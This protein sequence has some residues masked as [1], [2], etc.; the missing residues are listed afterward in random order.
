MSECLASFLSL[1]NVGH[2]GGN[3]VHD[4]HGATIACVKEQKIKWPGSVELSIE[5]MT[6]LRKFKEE[7]LNNSKDIKYVLVYESQFGPHCVFIAGVNTV[8]NVDFFENVNSWGPDDHAPRVEVLKKKNT[9]FKVRARWSPKDCESI[10]KV[11][12]SEKSKVCSG[13]YTAHYCSVK[14]SQ[15]DWPVHENMC[16]K[17]GGEFRPL[18]LEWNP[19]KEGSIMNK[20][21][22]TTGKIKI[23]TKASQLSEVKHHNIL[24]V[25]KQFDDSINKWFVDKFDAMKTTFEAMGMTEFSERCNKDKPAKA[26]APGFGFHSTALT[27]YSQHEDIIG[28]ISPKSPLCATLKRSIEEGGVLSYKIYINSHQKDGKLMVNPCRILRPRSW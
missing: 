16:K 7:D 19:K 12:L 25:Q 9:V 2:Q 20:K 4:F 18:R 27:V 17:M 21:N 24:K 3:W 11:C 28:F 15:E 10:C 26:G 1:P 13:C 5:G 23:H 14:C 22:R 8:N 6:D